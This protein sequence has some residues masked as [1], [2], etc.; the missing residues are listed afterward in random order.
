MRKTMKVISW[1]V[2]LG[3]IALSGYANYLHGRSMI[4]G[5]MLAVV[6]VGFAASV[7]ILEGLISAGKAHRATFGAIFF[8]ALASGVASYLGL[9]GMAIDSGI[10]RAQSL[11][12]PLS[13]DGVV[14]VA[15]MG[16]RGFS[17]TPAPKVSRSRPV[18][19]P[20]D[21]PTGV[22]VS[23]GH[24]PALSQ[25]DVPPDPP[26]SRAG[27]DRDLARKLLSEGQ[28]S[29]ADIA[30]RVGCSRKSIDRLAAKV[31]DG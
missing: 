19:V 13:F 11:L 1:L 30:A 23:Q 12:L 6:P 29:R 26:V 22:P 15:S 16:I 25:A 31:S 20:A 21:V 3:F 24:V 18:R 4:A 27:W 2:F 5:G 10:S 28:L 8:V 14:L 7:F 17:L 9:Y